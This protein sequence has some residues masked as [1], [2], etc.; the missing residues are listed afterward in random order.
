MKPDLSKPLEDLRYPVDPA[1]HRTRLDLFLKHKLNWRSR[2]S[3]RTL[4][5]EGQILV[6]GSPKGLKRSRKLMAGDDVRVLI[7][8]PAEG[9]LQH[10]SIPLEILY[11][12]EWFLALNKQSG[13]L[14]HPVSRNLYNTLINALHYKYRNLEDPKKDVVPRLAHRLDRDTTGVLLVAKTA[15]IRWILQ[16]RIE[17]GLVRKTYRAIVTGV[18]EEDEGRIDHPIGKDPTGKSKIK[19]AVREDGLPSLTTFRVAQRF[20][21]HT[22]V[23]VGLHTGRTHQIRVHMESLGHPVCGDPLYGPEAYK[24][25]TRWRA[26]EEE[27]SETELV[28]GK[29]ADSLLPASRAEAAESDEALRPPR[30]CLHAERLELDHPQNENPLVITAEFPQDL[31][32]FLEELRLAETSSPTPQL[33]PDLVLQSEEKDR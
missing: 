28:R 7:P 22:V 13:I 1:F 9:E 29:N 18:V 5:E 12:D 16:K 19:M 11:E 27:E 17:R 30:L 15:R 26:D 25:A 32:E 8:K 4:I 2:N 20:S 33:Q 23:E 14:C 21:H 24:F 10:D 6:N 3:I 31:R